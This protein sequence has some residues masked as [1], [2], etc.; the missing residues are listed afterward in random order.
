MTLGLFFI[1]AVFVF[2][3]LIGSFLNV[4]ILRLPA[5]ETL[6]GRS[7]CP[8]YGHV[9]TPRDLIPIFSFLFLRGRCRSC[10]EKISWRY[11]FIELL[12]ACVFVSALLFVNPVALPSFFHLGILWVA[13]AVG[14]VT[15]IV[16]MEHYII[17]DIV[18]FVGVVFVLVFSL[19]LDIF[20]HSSSFVTG[21]T[22]HALLGAV[23]GFLPFFALWWFSAGRWIGFGDVK[24]M[25]FVGAVAGFPLVFISMLFSFWIGAL[26]SLPLLFLGRKGLKSKL[27]FGTF[28]TLGMA[29]SLLFG[30]P[31]LSWYTSLIVMK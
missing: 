18:T 25:L 5:G 20:V 21:Y 28:L 22:I 16:D 6:F 27:P 26:V 17:L 12:T 24:F 1:L 19:C 30:T 4:V 14:I 2:G 9:L 31:L 29:T 10:Q 3:L 23:A 7:A 15:F 13:G 11:F 8:R